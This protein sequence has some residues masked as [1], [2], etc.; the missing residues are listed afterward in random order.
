[1]VK[2]VFLPLFLYSPRPFKN[3][4]VGNNKHQNFYADITIGAVLL[5]FD[6]PGGGG[7]VCV[8]G[9]GES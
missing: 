6:F 8:C 7:N 4:N 2:E 3:E 9:G 5:Y 1:M